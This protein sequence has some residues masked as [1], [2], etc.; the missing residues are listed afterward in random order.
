MVLCCLAEGCE[1]YRVLCV[2]VLED[3]SDACL[4]VSGVSIGLR[5]CDVEGCDQT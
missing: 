3:G 2:E 4:G 1:E 5:F